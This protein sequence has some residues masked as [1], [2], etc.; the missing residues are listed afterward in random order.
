MSVP[1]NNDMNIIALIEKLQLDKSTIAAIS[2]EEIIRIEKRINMEKRLD[3]DIDTNSAA[4]LVEA[5]RNYQPELAYVCGTRVFY[6]FLA[7]RNHSRNSFNFQ[8]PDISADRIRYF[9]TRFL[10]DAVVLH[11]ERDLS[12]NYFFSLVSVCSRKEYLPEDAL[13]K[14]HKKLLGK[15]DFAL[16]ELQSGNISENSKSII[17]NREFYELL[18]CFSDLETDDKMLL[19]VNLVAKKYNLELNS[20]EVLRTV[21]ISMTAYHPFDEEL[22]GVIERNYTVMTAPVTTSGNSSDSSFPWWKT[23]GLVVLGLRVIFALFRTSNTP[24]TNYDSTTFENTENFKQQDSNIDKIYF[25]NYLVQYKPEDVKV[26][27]AK[28]T[29]SNGEVPFYGLYGGAS[30]DGGEKIKIRN[31]SKYDLI[32]LV[33]EE[34]N[35]KFTPFSSQYVNSNATIEISKKSLYPRRYAFYFGENLASFGSGDPYTRGEGKQEYR[36]SKLPEN[37]LELL[38]REFTLKHDLVISNKKEKFVFKSDSISCVSDQ[39]PA[40]VNKFVFP[41]DE[42]VKAIK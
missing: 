12:E 1:N 20:R 34:A 37:G 40:F 8:V 27:F 36:F 14:I 5:L 6:N 21:L 9:F 33:S 29:I 7:D 35:G 42:K 11:A 17:A 22:A 16:G 3:P 19:L 18:D 15:I 2:P 4:N 38:Y 41:A 25:L 30:A 32:L 31:N 23:I 24:S 13:F 10:E 26:N 39:N 28:A